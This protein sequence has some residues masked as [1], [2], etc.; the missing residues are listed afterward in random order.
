MR[1]KT[2]ESARRI[3]LSSLL[4]SDLTITEI[5]EIGNAFIN[6]SDFSDRLGW[7]IKDAAKSI[8]APVRMEQAKHLTPDYERY[9]DAYP[10]AITIINKRRIPK[11]E[12]LS[13]LK[14]LRPEIRN[15]FQQSKRNLTLREMVGVFFESASSGEID[16]F[17]DW[18]EK[19][20]I[21]SDD[22]L[23]GIM[24]KR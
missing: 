3:I 18:L 6:E 5:Q 7:L 20:I 11:R 17:M 9:D 10:K 15:Y 8:D 21:T 19:R 13:I 14:A 23:K 4:T 24:R 12:I 1:S 22:Y 16:K 2:W